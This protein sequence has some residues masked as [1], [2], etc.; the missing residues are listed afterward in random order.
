MASFEPGQ[1]V[2]HDDGTWGRVVDVAPCGYRGHLITVR[3]FSIGP[4]LP[5]QHWHTDETSLFT[6]TELR[7]LMCVWSGHPNLAS[8]HGRAA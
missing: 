2:M 5:L 1:T 7:G 6:P 4:A 3:P 8:K